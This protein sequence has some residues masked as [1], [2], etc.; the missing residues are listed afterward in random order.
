MHNENICTRVRKSIQGHNSTRYS[1][2]V[3][4]I[5]ILLQDIIDIIVANVSLDFCIVYQPLLN[6][7]KGVLGL[8]Y[9]QISAVHLKCG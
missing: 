8:E 2:V 3:T 9:M 6:K 1:L 5:P 7:C 4:A